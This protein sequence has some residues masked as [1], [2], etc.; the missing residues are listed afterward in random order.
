[1]PDAPIPDAENN[2]EIKDWK[3]L[4]TDPGFTVIIGFVVLLIGLIVVIIKPEIKDVYMPFSIGVVGLTGGH[5]F[6]DSNKTKYLCNKK[7]DH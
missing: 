1:M 3:Q 7:E 2:I 6:S 5:A 4:L